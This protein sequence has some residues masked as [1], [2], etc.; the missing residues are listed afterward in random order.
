[1]AVSFPTLA[2]AQRPEPLS[3][4]ADLPEMIGLGNA[5]FLTGRVVNRPNGMQVYTESFGLQE[6]AKT[7]SDTYARAFQ[8]KGWRVNNASGMVSA[9]HSKGYECTVLLSAANDGKYKTR[10]MVNYTIR[11]TR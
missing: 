10:A 7:A 3:K 8:S 2:Q 1:M 4:P 11:A 5:T 9:T 6:D